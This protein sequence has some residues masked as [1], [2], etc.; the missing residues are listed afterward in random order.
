VSAP[1]ALEDSV[2]PRRSVG[3]SGRPLNF[4]VRGH[5]GKSGVWRLGVG[6]TP[7][8]YRVHLSI[9]AGSFVALI[10]SVAN[11]ILGLG[12]FGR[13]ARAVSA[14]TIL[15]FLVYGA[16][17]MPTRRE[18]REYVDGRRSPRHRDTQ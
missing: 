13:S 9:G 16:F 15:V 14:L 10:F 7:L 17:F 12:F 6:M 2:R 5:G 1:R 11:D 3:A 4:T 18:L 8:A